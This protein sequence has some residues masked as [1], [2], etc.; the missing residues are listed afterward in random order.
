MTG[1]ML[2]VSSF[3]F[4]A[5]IW[6][7]VFLVIAVPGEILVWCKRDLY[8]IKHRS[9]WISLLLGF[10]IILWQVFTCLQRI[11][12]ADYPCW[13]SLWAGQVGTI[14]TCNLFVIRCWLLHSSYTLA[15]KMI[16]D[17]NVAAVPVPPPPAR[18]E[19]DEPDLRN[20][21]Y[22]SLQRTLLPILS[23]VFFVLLLPPAIASLLFSE[24]S[25]T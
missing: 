14:L 16:T 2:D 9:P 19:D 1:E 11:Y 5:L 12:V 25:D 15:Q 18:D 10:L 20:R 21:A 8:P 24:L 4:V 7:C 3:A 6:L 22:S 13:I 17:T 23:F